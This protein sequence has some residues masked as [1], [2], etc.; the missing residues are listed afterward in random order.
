M[1]LYLGKNQDQPHLPAKEGRG[2]QGGTEPEPA[3][4]LCLR[5]TIRKI[6]HPKL[7]FWVSFG[8]QREHLPHTLP[9]PSVITRRLAHF[10]PGEKV[11]S[12]F[13]GPDFKQLQPRHCPPG[14]GRSQRVPSLGNVSRLDPALSNDPLLSRQTVALLPQ[15]AFHASLVWSCGAF[16][17]ENVPATPDLSLFWDF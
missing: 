1:F 12:R 14:D 17:R 5:R 7:M 13:T 6:F 10:Q 15:Q 2:E 16:W 11:S 3:A 9:S 4:L 8:T